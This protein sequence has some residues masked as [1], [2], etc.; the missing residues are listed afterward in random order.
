MWLNVVLKTYLSSIQHK[1]LTLLYVC[2]WF[3]SNNSKYTNSRS[4]KLISNNPKKQFYDLHTI[5]RLLCWM[6]ERY[7]HI[8]QSKITQLSILDSGEILHTL[9]CGRGFKFLTTKWFS[10]TSPTHGSALVSMS[11]VNRI[12]SLLLTQNVRVK[13]RFSI[14]RSFVN[15]RRAPSVCPS[16]ST[17]FGPSD[18]LERST[19][20]SKIRQSWWRGKGERTPSAEFP[21]SRCN[22]LKQ[23]TTH[24]L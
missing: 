1:N 11:H 12:G 9:P 13:K 15:R 18:W 10:L 4:L 14:G 7:V 16:V 6:N 21:L 2:Y 24:H 22:P 20:R 23:F 19:L 5:S 8:R 3:I 17:Q